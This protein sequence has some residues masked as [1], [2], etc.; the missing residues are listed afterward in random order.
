MAARRRVKPSV[1]MVVL[2]ESSWSFCVC[3]NG[4]VVATVFWSPAMTLDPHV[5]R[6][7][8]APRVPASWWWLDVEEPYEHVQLATSELAEGDTNEARIAEFFGAASM[9]LSVIP[10]ELRDKRRRRSGASPR[11]GSQRT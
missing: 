6:D 5:K 11:S 4:R 3:E 9:A 10:R 1:D 2:G 7:A 8:D